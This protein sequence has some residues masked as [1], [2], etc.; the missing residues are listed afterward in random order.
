MI[1]SRGTTP[2]LGWLWDPKAVLGGEGTLLQNKTE[3]N[4][5]FDQ[6]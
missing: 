4:K 5:H 6:D 1:V 2:T 3:S